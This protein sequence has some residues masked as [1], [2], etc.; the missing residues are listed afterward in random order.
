MF[1]KQIKNKFFK[2]KIID[3]FDFIHNDCPKAG[4]LSHAIFSEI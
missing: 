3:L 4:F 2:L 1:Y